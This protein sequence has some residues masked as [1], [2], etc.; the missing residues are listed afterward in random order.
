MKDKLAQKRAEITQGNSITETDLTVE[1]WGK[2]W[3]Q[4]FKA[5][6]VKHSTM[7]NYEGN[8]ANHIVP[9]LGSIKLKDLTTLSVQRMYL[10][11][12][13]EGLSPKSIRNVHGMLHGMLDKAVKMDMVRRNVTDSCELP[14]V[15]KV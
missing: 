1:Q 3:L 9:Y 13:Q 5:K 8:F 2:E 6:K 11:L 7:D 4:T 14:H 10:R 12:E 15:Q